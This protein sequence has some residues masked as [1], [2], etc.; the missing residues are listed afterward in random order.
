MLLA[1]KPVKQD[2]GWTTQNNPGRKYSFPPP[3]FWVICTTTKAKRPL[4]KMEGTPNWNPKLRMMRAKK[5]ENAA[6][7]IYPNLTYFEVSA[8]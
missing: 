3:A 6:N 2:K 1:N 8:K 5:N 4:P 7:N